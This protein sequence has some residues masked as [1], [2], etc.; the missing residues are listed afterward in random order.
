MLILEEEEHALKRNAPIIARLAGYCANSDGYD[1]VSPSGEGATR[2]MDEALEIYG[3]NIDYINAH[4]TSTPVGD[5]AELGA[6]KNVFG[7]SGPVIGMTPKAA[8]HAALENNARELEV[9]SSMEVADTS[10]HGSQSPWPR[11]Q[12]SRELLYFSI[13]D[14]LHEGRSRD[15]IQDLLGVSTDEIAVVEKLLRM[16]GR[17]ESGVH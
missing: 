2:C 7:D 13:L 1:M 10:K 16:A 15:E 4:G 3:G 11:A 6:I 9:P 5:L 17:S 8:A 14:L 12:A